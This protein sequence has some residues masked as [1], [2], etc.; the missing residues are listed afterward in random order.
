MAD[1]SQLRVKRQRVH[2]WVTTRMPR[3]SS[4]DPHCSAGLTLHHRPGRSHPREAPRC[5]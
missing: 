2:L 3:P 4:G 1:P 5:T